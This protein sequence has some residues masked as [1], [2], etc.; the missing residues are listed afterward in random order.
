MKRFILIFIIIISFVA[1]AEA[2]WYYRKCNVADINNCTIEEFD[3]LWGKATTVVIGGAITT[4][5]GTG[6][7]VY[8]YIR[9]NYYFQPGDLS[10]L[11]TI[12]AGLILNLVGIPVWVT[13]AVR[14]NELR[15][16]AN[17]Q[18]LHSGCLNISPILGLNQ[19]NK[20][21]CFGLSLSINF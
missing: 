21:P 10:G 5:L 4:A 12:P 2:Q 20:S 1:A 16:T 19:F 8:A 6:L 9:E 7:L 13:G 18:N 15:K 11:I 3:C 14:R 17:Y